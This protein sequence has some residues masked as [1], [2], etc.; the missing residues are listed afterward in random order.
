MSFAAA[1]GWLDRLLRNIEG[2]LA[3]LAA[4]AVMAILV[5]TT[6]DVA[7]RYIFN[8]PLGWVFD[9]VMHF[10]LGAAFFLAFPLALGRGD[11]IAVDFV[12][13]R[14]PGRPVHLCMAPACLAAA[15]LLATMG[16]FG[17]VEVWEA[18]QAD[19][20]IAGVILWP[21]WLARLS[22]PLA[23]AP[24]VLRLVHIGLSH[25]ATALDA[26]RFPYA[27]PRFHAAED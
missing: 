17:A 6:A 27:A 11:H 9:L 19:D 1:M 13:H 5:L 10:L 15:L 26:T 12:A 25:G 24:M 21:V 8:A 16:W 7:M 23:M 20:R 2:G 22:L 4:L 18:W 3:A 14:L